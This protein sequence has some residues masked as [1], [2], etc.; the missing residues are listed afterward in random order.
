MEVRCMTFTLTHRLKESQLPLVS[1][2]LEDC[3]SSFYWEL[4]Y[5]QTF[6]LRALE[7]DEVC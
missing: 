6:T 3:T 4:P 5:R 7:C 1:A 2:S